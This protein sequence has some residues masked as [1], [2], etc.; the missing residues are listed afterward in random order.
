MRATGR[1]RAGSGDARHRRDCLLPHRPTPRRGASGRR[2]STRRRRRSTPAQDLQ[3]FPEVDPARRIICPRSIYNGPRLWRFEEPYQD[4][5]GSGDFSYPVSGDPGAAP[6]PEPFCDYNHNGRWDGIYLSGRRQP[7][8]EGGAR[9]DRRPGGRLLRRLARPSC[10]SPWSPRASSR[11]TSARRARRRRRSPARLRT[12]RA[13]ATSTR[14]SSAPTTTR[15]RPTRSASTARPRTRPGSFGLNS[16]DRRVLH[17][18]ARRADGERRGR[19]L[20]RPPAGLAA[21]GRVPRPGRT[22]SRRSR[23]GSRPPTDTGNAGGDRS[24]GARAAGPRRRAA[25]RSSR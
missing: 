14:W 23:R 22:S 24:Q 8:G 4:T 13:A 19:R 3:D 25:T 16:C 18:L 1:D 11:T 7:P 21:G 15:A 2:R 12:R 20:R 5:D 17:G 6:A 10:S 9:P